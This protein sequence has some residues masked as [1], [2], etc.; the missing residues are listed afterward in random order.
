MRAIL[1]RTH[2]RVQEPPQ[3][4]VDARWCDGSGTG[5]LYYQRRGSSGA[6]SR[7][8]IGPCKT[9]EHRPIT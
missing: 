2:R 3:N 6:S 9:A 7:L 5:T 8:V 4:I 1:S